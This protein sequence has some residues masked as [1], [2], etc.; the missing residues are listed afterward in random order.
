M[1]ALILAVLLYIP[2]VLVITI[3]LVVYYCIKYL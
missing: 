3:V 2:A 1:I